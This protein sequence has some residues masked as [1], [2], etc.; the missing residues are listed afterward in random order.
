MLL[1]HSYLKRVKVVPQK[2]L[3]IP[4]GGGGEGS[5]EAD[6]EGGFVLF[7]ELAEAF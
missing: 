6:E 7:G 1:S 2:V 3:Q 5:F 4:L